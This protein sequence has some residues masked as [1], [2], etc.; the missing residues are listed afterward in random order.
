MSFLQPLL[1]AALPLIALPILIHLVN[2]RRYQTMPW[3]AMIFLLAANRLS[4]GFAR[5]RQWLILAAR[6]LVVA[7][8]IFALARPLASGWLGLAAGSRADTTII[9][10]DRSPSMS[11]IS[12]GG[13][14]TK[15][16]AG[17]R[18]LAETLEK[19]GSDHWVLID[20]ATARPVELQSPQALLNAPETEPVGASA[21]LPAMLRA[22]YQYMQSNQTGRTDIWICSDMRK[23]DWDAEGG[24][25]PAIRE[26]FVDLPQSVRFYLLAFP[27][28]SQENTSL[29]VTN[30]RRKQTDQGATLI[31]SLNIT[32]NGAT[33]EPKTVPVEFDID[34]ARS[35]IDIEMNGSTHELKNHE[36]PLGA[37]Q[38]QGWGRVAIPADSNNLDNEFFFVFDQPPVRKTLLVADEPQE[39]RALRL[40]AEIAAEADSQ[41][42]VE[43]SSPS[44]LS[45]IAWEEIGLVLWQAPLP[46]G[47]EAKLLQSF[48]ESDGRVILFPP[49]SPGSNSFYDLSWGRWNET[50]E[51]VIVGNWRGDADLLA[52]TQSGAALP[53]G[54]L[55]FHKTCEIVGEMTPL[56]T[57]SNG[58]VLLGRVPT[59][60][61]G[62]YA[63]ATTTADSDSSLAT[64][65]VVLYV[66]VQRALSEGCER[67]GQVRQKVA[68]TIEGDS[69]DWKRL[70]GA[71]LALS[72]QYAYHSGVFSVDEKLLALNRA[73]AEDATRA[74]SDGK[75]SEL[76]DGLDLVQID[77]RVGESSSLVQEIWRMFL[78]AMLVALIAEAFLCLPKIRSAERAL[79]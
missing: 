70:T 48:V 32:R 73:T 19:L 62:V 78:I 44:Q 13:V 72:N 56:A 76:F 36:I 5:L 57:L 23:H 63:L 3:G 4:R 30:V 46:D 28:E 38:V 61:G 77:N 1:L 65:G 50:P 47:E 21:N 75:I 26:S 54:E 34:G 29:R 71:E 25:W 69:S 8:L 55:K 9:L 39:G 15:L 41:N 14:S 12:S 31:V 45:S 35:T 79:A 37:N 18:H 60:H 66:M 43:L 16:D 7:G 2:Q 52:H 74:L 51:D 53:V 40:A 64:D 67:L 17:K 33:E 59:A 6:T 68:G 58:E 11:A 20:S 49:Q 10:L 24:Q 27:Q 22:A 42:V